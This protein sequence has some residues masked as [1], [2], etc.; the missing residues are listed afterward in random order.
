MKKKYSS[1]PFIPLEKSKEAKAVENELLNDSQN[2]KLYIQKEEPIDLITAFKNRLKNDDQIS[3]INPTGD[4]TSYGVEIDLDESDPTFSVEYT[5]D[6]IGFK[7]LSV[8]QETGVCDFGS[9]EEIITD[10]FGVEPVLVKDGK[11]FAKLD[12]ND[13]DRILDNSFENDVVFGFEFDLNTK[14][15]NY[16]DNAVGY[17]PV[18]ISTEGFKAGSWE[19]VISKLIACKPTAINSDREW[20]F[21]IDPYEYGVKASQENV[22]TTDVFVRFRHLYYYLDITADKITFKISNYKVNDNFVDDIFEGKDEMYVSAYDASKDIFDN[23]VSLSGKT[24]TTDVDPNYYT[25]EL[26]NKYLYLL[27]L[28]VLIGGTFDMSVLGINNT[29]NY[30]KQTGTLDN[31]GLFATDGKKTKIFGIEDPFGNS[32]FIEDAVYA[33]G[34]TLRYFASDEEI[35]SDSISINKIIRIRSNDLSMNINGC[36][37][38]VGYNGVAIDISV[39]MK[40]FR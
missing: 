4:T 5:G 30:I 2:G 36:N 21:D 19:E 14:E 37:F 7:R 25:K 39:P 20:K 12:P 11:E 16:T 13:Y 40:I 29:E 10:F 28:G 18:L 32:S 17:E 3:I 38:V 23:Y 24:A 34:S 1:I 6:A 15:F 26:A 8:N 27:F 33:D 9:W 22:D 35:A 31:N